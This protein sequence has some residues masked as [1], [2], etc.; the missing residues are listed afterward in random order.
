LN[1]VAFVDK[2][3]YNRLSVSQVVDADLDVLFAS[4]VREFLILLAILFVVFLTLAKSFKMI[5]LLLNL[6]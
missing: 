3:R 6:L 2:L 5:F 1:D 4:L